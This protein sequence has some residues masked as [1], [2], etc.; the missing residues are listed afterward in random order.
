[1]HAANLA[2]DD[3]RPLYNGNIS[4]MAVNINKLIY[5]R[6]AAYHC[7][8]LNRVKARKSYYNLDQGN[9]LWDN[10]Q[11]T[12]SFQENFTY[13]ANGN[14]LTADRYTGATWSTMDSLTYSYY[15]GTNRLRRVRELGFNH[16]GTTT[17]PDIIDQSD[18]DNY[19]Y[20]EIGNLT[21]DVQEGITNIKWSV[22]GK[23]L[24]IDRTATT[25]NPVVKIRY[26][27]DASGNRIS[28]EVRKSGTN[29]VEYSWYVRDAQ[30]NVMSTYTANGDTAGVGLDGL[31]LNVI[32]QPL[33][34]SSRVG[35]LTRYSN[36][37]DNWYPFNERSK[38]RGLKQYELSNHL[39][40]VLAT[41][42]DRKTPVQSGSD[43][44]K[45]DHFNA[46]V[47]NAYDYYAFGMV[48]PDRKFTGPGYRYG[49]NGKENDREVKG[50][51]N[52]Y[53]YGFRIYDSRIGRFLSV[54]PLTKTYPWYTPYQ[55]AG[56]KPIWATD[57]DGLEENT[58]ST[59]VYKP[60][61]LGL[62]PAFRGVI[63]ITNATSQTAHRTFEGDISKLSKAD[64]SGF[65]RGIV[66]ALVGSNIGTSESRLDITQTGTRSEVSKSWR[67][68]DMKYFT[69]YSYT[70]TN[71]NVT[72]VGTFEMQTGT[73]QASA[74]AWDPLAAILLNRVVKSIVRVEV[75]ASASTS[76]GII[77]ETTESIVKNTGMTTVG[78]WMSKTEYEI[79][80]NT[81]RMVE[82][83][84]GQ[85]FVATGGPNAFTAA[86][87]G[88]VYAEFEVPTSSLLQ[89]GQSNWFKI[90]GPNAG[91]AMK[92]ALKKQG[93]EV[94]PQ[95][96]NL[97]PVI[98][99]K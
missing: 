76:T 35:V 59:Y 73:V 69:Q 1:M 9:N 68:T 43:P 86:A 70:F 88:S 15:P 25:N 34:G 36:A 81:G 91:K 71:N 51:G 21:S 8:Q 72:E 64:Q 57:V 56:N 2:A 7:D 54:D 37:E 85:T 41:V 99:V 14:I 52:Q 83:A 31:Q 33:Y 46:E 44:N 65:S 47:Q 50:D 13:D 80:A 93:G 53:D 48:M 67:G 24:E 32:D 3:Y 27:Y 60:S 16:Y 92:A 42:S 22:S 78:R 62:R 87:K 19:K 84:G 38:L 30:G 96:Q 95:I 63:S 82:G 39:G 90:I 40:N 4:S 97:S 17:N 75:S 98:Q 12:K 5:P 77:P 61:V 10:L 6:V 20:D 58:A 89:G 29:S 79:M 94:L 26:G 74:R 18:A 23:I 28:K 45:V 49:F 11:F 55:F 66:N